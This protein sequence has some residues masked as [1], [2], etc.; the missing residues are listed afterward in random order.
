MLTFD[1]IREII[2]MIDQSSIQHF[3]LNQDGTQIVVG[4]YAV[5]SQKNTPLDS[6][7]V[8]ETVSQRSTAAIQQESAKIMEEIEGSHLHKILS[9]TVGT[10][11]SAPE[12]G[13]DPFVKMGQQ[14]GPSTVVCVL[15]AMKL[16]NEVEAGISGE[17]VEILFKDGEFVE[18]GA[19]LFLVKP[20]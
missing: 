13:A 1:E 18:Y 12:P 8:K 4:K 2:K 14:V 17:V 6:E 15:E 9:T 3:E 19:P 11:Y 20:E 16:F 5:S 7:G 10:F